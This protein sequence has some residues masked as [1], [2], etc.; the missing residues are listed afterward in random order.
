MGFFPV[1]A[2]TLD[3]LRLTGRAEEQVAAGRAVLPRNR[4]CSATRRRPDPGY[5]DVLELDLATVEPS[6]AGPSGRRTAWRSARSKT[7]FDAGAAAPVAERGFGLAPDALGRRATG[8]RRRY[9]RPA[10]RRG[11]HRRHHQL[12]QHVAIPSVMMAAGLLAKKAVERGLTVPPGSRPAWRPARG[13]SPTTSR[14]RLLGRWRRWASTPSATAAPPAS[15]TAARCRRRSPAAVKAGDLVAA[16]GAERQPQLRGPDQSAV[17]ANYLAS[18]P[19]VVAY[20][21]AG[22]NGHRPASRAAGHRRRR[23]ARTGSRCRRVPARA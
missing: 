8:G 16:V 18:P 11:G 14:G 21:L 10:P 19:L 5:T 20:A 17:K 6:L 22:T 4:A 9:C 12:H 23:A 1:D 13:W 2:E 7:A 15:A 3:Y